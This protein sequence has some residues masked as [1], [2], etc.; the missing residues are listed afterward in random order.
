M[1]L[2]TYNLLYDLVVKSMP[3]TLT[4]LRPLAGRLKTGPNTLR[5]LEGLRNEDWIALFLGD[6]SSNCRTP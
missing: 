5:M 3:E 4:R 1:S 6:R 2:G